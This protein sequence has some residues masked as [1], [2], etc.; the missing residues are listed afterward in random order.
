MSRMLL[1]ER[2]KQ[3]RFFLDG[4]MGTQLIARGAD[5]SAGSEYLN[6]TNPQV[7]KDVHLAYYQAGSD[8]V[9]TNTFGANGLSLSRH[10]LAGEIDSINEA[11]VLNAKKAREATE[12][13]GGE[14]YILGGLGPCGELL[15]PYGTAKAEDLSASFKEQA[16]LLAGEGVDGIIIETMTAIEEAQVAAKAVRQVTDLPLFVSMAFDSGGGK[17]RTNMG[18]DA[19]TLVEV[20]LAIGVNALGFNC[21]TMEMSDYVE[22]A[23]VFAELLEDERVLLLAEAN[24]GKPEYAEGQTV[25]KLSAQDFAVEGHR[26]AKAGACLL[27]GCCGTTPEH[28][29]ALVSEVR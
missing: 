5:T 21:G 14:K 12:S 3:G 15:E 16:N 1:S 28:I 23:G 24:A 9:I 19:K 25:F 7:V 13:S 20:M 29:A 18:V 22:L 4:A 2:I 10:D 8:A 6:I 26:I 27:G 17:F 11:A